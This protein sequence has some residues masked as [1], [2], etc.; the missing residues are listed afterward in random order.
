[1][2]LD[3]ETRRGS[4]IQNYLPAASGTISQE[5]RQTF[6]SFIFATPI[7][8]IP[9]VWSVIPDEA[10]GWTGQGDTSTIWTKQTDESTV[11]S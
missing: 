9:E 8:I 3:T 7:S 11:W 1:M 6:I 5:E 2:A 10:S 4:L